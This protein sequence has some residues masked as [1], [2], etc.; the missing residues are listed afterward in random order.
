MT[1]DEYV[2]VQAK[3]V[4]GNSLPCGFD[5]DVAER[6]VE[7]LVAKE[8]GDDAEQGST[9]DKEVVREE[10]DE[11]PDEGE[12]DEEEAQ[13]LLITSVSGDLPC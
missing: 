12:D 6:G 1:D 3:I 8:G 10:G 2:Q 11:D 13:E 7:Q 9:E 4:S 5:A